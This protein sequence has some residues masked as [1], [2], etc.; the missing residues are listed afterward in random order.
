MSRPRKRL[1]ALAGAMLLALVIGGGLPAFADPVPGTVTGHLTDDGSPVADAS[2]TVTDPAT[3]Q[4]Y[5]AVTD[6]TGAFTVSGVAPGT[7][8]VAFRLPGGAVQYAVQQTSA[9]TAD[10]ITVTDG[11]VTVLEEAVAPHGSISGRVTRADGSPAALKTVTAQTGRPGGAASRTQTDANGD[12]VL[13]VVWPGTYVLSFGGFGSVTQYAHGQTSLQ[14]AD[15]FEVAAGADVT[16]DETLLPTG[17]VAGRLTD[18]AGQPVSVRPG[19]RARADRPSGSV[20]PIRTAG[21]GSRSCR[22]RTQWSSA[23]RAAWSSTPTRSARSSRPTRS[24]SP[25]VRTPL[26]TSSCWPPAPSRG[27]WSTRRCAGAGGVHPG[28]RRRRGHGLRLHVLRRVVPVQRRH[29]GRTRSVFKTS[30]GEQW[31]R[32][33]SSAETADPIVVIAGQTTLLN[34]SLVPPRHDRRDRARPDDRSAG[35]DVLRVHLSSSHCTED[36]TVTLLG[37]CRARTW[38]PSTMLG[39]ASRPMPTRRSRACS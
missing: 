10:L 22:G 16:V 24:P 15:R 5:F 14:A 27:A 17:A 7:Y 34:E 31:A 2:V 38:S 1:M 30:I 35:H 6:P 25:P 13:P 9:Q 11:G 20:P 37:R 39:R 26:W 12:Y 23:R 29:P 28:H 21:T 36:G 3:F 8:R 32:G 4:S 19:H 33:K 18:A